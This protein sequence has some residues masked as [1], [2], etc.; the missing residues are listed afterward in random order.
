MFIRGHS[1]D[2]RSIER[3]YALFKTV[4]LTSREHDFFLVLTHYIIVRHIEKYN[5]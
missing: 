1:N 2:G 3:E 5:V 4:T